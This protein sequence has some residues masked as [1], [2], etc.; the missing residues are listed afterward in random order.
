MVDVDRPGFV[1]DSRPWV[2]G[3]GESGPEGRADR[4]RRPRRQT[5]TSRCW[6]AA[7]GPR[8]PAR[9][10][11]SRAATSTGSSTGRVGT[12]RHEAVRAG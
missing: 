8:E 11:P 5:S 7:S 10:R 12:G 9:A 4:C 6:L 3:D 1:G 2:V